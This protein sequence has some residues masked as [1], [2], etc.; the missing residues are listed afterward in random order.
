MFLNN[1]VDLKK[2]LLPECSQPKVLVPEI[3]FAVT[4][5][6]H[7]GIGTLPI[8]YYGNEEQ[9]KKYLPKLASGE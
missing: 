8:L 7:T 4:I 3:L 5:A 6:A 1:T 9:K 2:I